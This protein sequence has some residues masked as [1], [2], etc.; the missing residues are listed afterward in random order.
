MIAGLREKNICNNLVVNWRNWTFW[1]DDGVKWKVELKISTITI[2]FLEIQ[3]YAKI[4]SHSS[5]LYSLI[6]KWKIGAVFYWNIEVQHIRQKQIVYNPHE[7]E[8][9]HYSS[10]LS[11]CHLLR[12]NSP[13]L[14]R[15]HSK[16]FSGCLLPF[17]SFSVRTIP[18]CVSNVEIWALGRT[19]HDW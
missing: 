9:H 19:I 1:P 16:L 10:T 18:H 4:S 14:L 3:Y 8:S 13:G 17:A 7:C 12:S 15:G 11:F 5:F 6:E 2:M